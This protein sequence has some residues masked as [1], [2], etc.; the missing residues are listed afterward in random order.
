MTGDGLPDL[1]QVRSGQVEYRMNLGHGRF[2]ERG[3]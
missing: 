1:V 2:G 3:A